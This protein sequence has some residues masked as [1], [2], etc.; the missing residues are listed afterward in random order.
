MT[1]MPSVIRP[2]KIMSTIDW[3]D[4]AKAAAEYDE[5][6]DSEWLGTYWSEG[7]TEDE[8]QMFGDFGDFEAAVRQARNGEL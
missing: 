2:E 1:M 5:S 7:L 6:S 4:I 8:Q 3:T